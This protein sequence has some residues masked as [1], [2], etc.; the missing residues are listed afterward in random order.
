MMYII[1]R[2]RLMILCLLLPTLGA[3]Y[4]DFIAGKK[5]LTSLEKILWQQRQLNQ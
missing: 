1:F 3:K 2:S 5:V 4:F